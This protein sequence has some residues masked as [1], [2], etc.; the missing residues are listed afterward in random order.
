M[1]MPTRN[2]V[3]LAGLVLLILQL[4]SCRRDDPPPRPGQTT[5]VF[6]PNL[7]YGTMT[8][9]DGNEYRTIGIGNQVWMAENLRVTRYSNG[10]PITFLP[11]SA[12]QGIFHLQTQG[13]YCAYDDTTHPDSIATYG[14]L[15]NGYAV[16][17]ERGLCPDGWRVPSDEDWTALVTHLDNGDNA[18]DPNGTGTNGVVG[19]RMKEVGYRHWNAPNPADNSSGFTAL[20]SGNRYGDIY[21]YKNERALFWT[22]T[23]YYVDTIPDIKGKILW[24]RGIG[25]LFPSIGRQAYPKDAGKCVRCIRN[26]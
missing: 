12:G 25:S 11:L 6:N 15:Y 10:D 8:D 21:Y 26:D 19:G 3:L 2:A 4:A 20:P 22:S 16:V 23:E 13:V 18:F 9:I 17:D 24:M 7:T 5:A 14:L 1:M